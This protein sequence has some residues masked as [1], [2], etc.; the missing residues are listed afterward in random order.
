MNPYVFEDCHNEGDIIV[1]EN[2]TVGNAIRMGG[3]IGTM[4][5]SHNITFDSCSN[6][7]DII[8]NKGVVCGNVTSSTTGY[9]R[10]GGFVGNQS[11]GTITV[12]NYVKNT[13]KIEV[14]GESKHSQNVTVGGV[15]GYT[16]PAFTED[17]DAVLINEG[18]VIFSGASKIGLRVGGVIGAAGATHPAAV[19][20]VNT[21]NITVTATYKSGETAYAGGVFGNT[22]GSQANAKSFCTI[23]AIGYTGVGAIT[24]SHYAAG[25]VELSN[26][27]AG[28]TMNS[29]KIQIEEASGTIEEIGPGALTA[30]NWFENFYGNAVEE[31]VLTDAG[32]SLLNEK[33]STAIPTPAEPEVA[34]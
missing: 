10:V 4:E 5:S 13:G 28:G 32:C 30:T 24:G 31:S 15:F 3:F 8:V 25:T 21:G 29:K 6:S 20:Y 34:E 9:I 26:C 11:A 1:K 12:K 2:V 7:G 19:S 27:A 22:S 23:N 14:A 18:E 16:K 33:P 17:S